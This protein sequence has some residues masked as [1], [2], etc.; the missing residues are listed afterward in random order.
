MHEIYS[1]IGYGDAIPWKLFLAWLDGD[2]VATSA[3]YVGCGVAQMTYVSA[4]RK[5]REMGYRI[6]VLQSSSGGKSI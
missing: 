2:P 1:Q 4:L 6:A 5:A 3:L